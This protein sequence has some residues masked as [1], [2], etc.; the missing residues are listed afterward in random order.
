MPQHNLSVGR[1]GEEL[2]KKFLQDKD[3]EIIKSHFTSHWGE[4]DIIAKKDNKLH[5]VEVKTRIDRKMGK[6]YEAVTAYKIR[7]LMRCIQF[8][9]LKFKMKNYKLSLDV[10]SII[11]NDDMSIYNFNWF[12]NVGTG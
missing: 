10:I 8:Y 5:F 7:S 6:P 9:I 4:L 11:L 3:F 1:Y 12:Q 2:A